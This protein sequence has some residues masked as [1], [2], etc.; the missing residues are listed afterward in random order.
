MQER[1]RKIE[2]REGKEVE[3]GEKERTR[4]RGRER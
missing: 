3:K 1:W 2:Q 4:R